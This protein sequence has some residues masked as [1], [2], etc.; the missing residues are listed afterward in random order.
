VIVYFEKLFHYA[1]ESIFAI[2][3]QLTRYFSRAA[4]L[5]LQFGDFMFNGVLISLKNLYK[6]P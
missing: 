1:Q 3:A 2:I 6:A 4:S 5:C